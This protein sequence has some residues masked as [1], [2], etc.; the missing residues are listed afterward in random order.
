MGR[1][2]AFRRV[3][4][5]RANV[6]RSRSLRAA[7][8]RVLTVCS[9]EGGWHA[10]TLLTTTHR[11]LDHP[12]ALLLE[13][14]RTTTKVRMDG[15]LRV[16]VKRGRQKR[17]RLDDHLVAKKYEIPHQTSFGVS[18]TPLGSRCSGSPQQALPF[19]PTRAQVPQKHRNVRHASLICWGD[20]NQISP[21]GGI[22]PHGILP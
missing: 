12:L 13:K 17:P 10:P 14:D 20:P 5:P 1:A 16:F 3:Q 11:P 2:S 7:W 19:G 6:L 8:L 9:C 22:T 21:G 15:S 18:P 4:R